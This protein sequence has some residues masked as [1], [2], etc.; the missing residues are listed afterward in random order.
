VST[1]KL[2]GTT[3]GAAAAVDS[4]HLL[5]YPFAEGLCRVRSKKLDATEACQERETARPHVRCIC[6][7]SCN[8]LSFS[9]HTDVLRWS[10][11]DSS[12]ANTN[13]RS[14]RRFPPVCPVAL[15]ETSENYTDL[16]R[17]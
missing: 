7:D 4:P 17:A 9:D 2:R 6:V 8:C 5:A 1:P 12:H 3:E 16:P 11:K 13:V 14:L 15:P 10:G